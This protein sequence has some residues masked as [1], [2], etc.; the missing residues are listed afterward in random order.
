MIETNDTYE[1]YNQSTGW[2]S[3]FLK[4]T[5]TSFFY[6]ILTMVAKA[7]I[8][9]YACKIYY[10]QIELN[11]RTLFFLVSRFPRQVQQLMNVR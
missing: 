5:L 4:R 10:S 3:V 8:H 9:E 7:A 11:M 2:Q 6:F 1:S